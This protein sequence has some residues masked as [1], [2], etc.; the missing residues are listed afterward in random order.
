[1]NNTPLTTDI[2]ITEFLIKELQLQEFAK[3]HLYPP[4]YTGICI[5]LSTISLKGIV[6]QNKYCEYLSKYIFPFISEQ[7]PFL[8]KPFLIPPRVE[9]LQ[10]L[11]EDLKKT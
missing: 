8:F 1:M 7:E 6:T 10:N 11:L 2:E 9:F 5:C 3:K 4:K